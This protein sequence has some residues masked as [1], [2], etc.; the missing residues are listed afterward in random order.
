MQRIATSREIQQTLEQLAAGRKPAQELVI[1]PETWEIEVLGPDQ[2]PIPDSM[3]LRP[4]AG[5]F[6]A[7]C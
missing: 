3:P 6:Y 1:N 7:R 4:V 5:D 2:R